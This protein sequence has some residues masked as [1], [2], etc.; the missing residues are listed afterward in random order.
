MPVFIEH[1]IGQ[2]ERETAFPDAWHASLPP[3]PRPQR[4]PPHPSRCMLLTTSQD[5]QTR[6]PHLA[7][8]EL[9][10]RLTVVWS[11]VRSGKL[12]AQTPLAHVQC[13][14][15]GPEQGGRRGS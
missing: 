9:P 13:H 1:A 2:F 5:A 8:C 14:S 12:V 4:S 10:E 11:R 15:F 6:A 7:K 3:E